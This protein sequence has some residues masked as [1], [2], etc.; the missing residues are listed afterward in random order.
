MK[1]RLGRRHAVP[2][3]VNAV[4][5]PVTKRLARIEDLLLEMRNEQDVKLKRLDKI[6]QR[7]DDLTETVTGNGKNV[8]RLSKLMRSLKPAQR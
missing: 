1:Q 7:L 8:D 4:V 2:P 5:Q 3:I 6:Q